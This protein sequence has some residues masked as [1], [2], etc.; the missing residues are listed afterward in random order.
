[1]SDQL[2]LLAVYLAGVSVRPGPSRRSDL[3]SE[4]GLG[5]TCDIVTTDIHTQ[6]RLVIMTNLHI[7]MTITDC[8][9]WLRMSQNITVER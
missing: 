1:M 7:L 4:L 2:T 3:H 6:V 9:A 5:V 8:R